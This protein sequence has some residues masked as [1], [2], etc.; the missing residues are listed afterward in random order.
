MRILNFGSLNIDHV[1]S[2]EHFV[3]PGETLGSR[4][5]QRFCGGKG[6][7]Q[8]I[9]L[10]HAGAKTFHAGMIGSEGE[11]LRARLEQAGADTRFV[12]LCERETGHAIIQIDKD[13]ENC[14]ILNGGANQAMTPEFIAEVFA[15]FST[16]DALLL[17]NEI[18]AMPEII[19]AGHDKGMRIFFNPAPM[20]PEVL[21]Y[22]LEMIDTFILNETEAAE[23]AGVEDPQEAITLLKKRYPQATLVITLGSKGALCQSREKSFQVAAPKVKAVDTT[24][25]GDTFTGFYLAAL[26]SGMDTESALKRGCAAAGICV[27]R[28][29]AADAIPLLKEIT[30]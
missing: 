25:A 2:V 21:S 19:R 20:S 5:Y 13:S 30:G 8:S 24:A 9:A 14:I 12:R 16:G 15:H 6:L 11:F 18:N 3:R 17:Q 22:P 26:M 4:S 1:Y 23:L 7:N 29:G 10:A 27:T 28:K